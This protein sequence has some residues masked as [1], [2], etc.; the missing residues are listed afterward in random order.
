MEV[1]NTLGLN[2]C[3]ADQWNAVD[4]ETLQDE[5]G[6]VRVLVNGPRY[7]VLDRIEAEGGVT[8]EGRQASFAG[9]DMALRGVLEVS[10]IGDV[11]GDELYTPNTIARSTG[12]TFYKDELVYLLVDPQGRVYIMQ[13]YAQIV[14]P[15][16]NIGELETLGERL[17]LPA[18]WRFEVTRLEENLVLSSD[19]ETTV[20]NDDFSNT[21]QLIPTAALLPYL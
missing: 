5:L 1:Y 17:K 16:L 20:I 6:A 21:Y 4:A 13:S 7:W 2:D 18:G 14:D 11:V 9:I 12:Y 10:V 8:S 19:G 15:N 3:P